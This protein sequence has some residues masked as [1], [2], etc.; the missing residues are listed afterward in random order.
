MNRL[1]PP[2]FLTPTHRC[3]APLPRSDIPRDRIDDGAA[4]PTTPPAVAGFDGRRRQRLLLRRRLYLRPRPSRPPRPIRGARRRRALRSGR[5]SRPAAARCRA[6]ASPVDGSSRVAA[7]AT[8]VVGIATEGNTVADD[9]DDRL[10]AP[11]LAAL[12]AG[13]TRA[14]GA[15]DTEPDGRRSGL[16]IVS[17]GTAAGG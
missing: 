14:L 2:S 1:S 5:V 6:A 4:T 9:D 15:A 11:D 7:A 8:A 12:P 3:P 17:R 13:A 16:F 10:L